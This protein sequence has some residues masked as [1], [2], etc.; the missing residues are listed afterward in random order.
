ML[1]GGVSSKVVLRHINME[2]H[3]FVG[4]GPEIRSHHQSAMPIGGSTKLETT[5]SV[6]LKIQLIE[7]LSTIVAYITCAYIGYQQHQS[8]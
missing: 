7:Y 2:E 5:E 3:Y 4:G 8:F 1:W 6:E